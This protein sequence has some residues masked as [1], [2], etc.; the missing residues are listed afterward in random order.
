MLT[1]G[2]L[3][4]RRTVSS[5]GCSSSCSSC[6]WEGWWPAGRGP[7]RPAGTARRGSRRRRVAHLAAGRWFGSAFARAAGAARP[8]AGLAP[9]PGARPV[10]AASPY[11]CPWSGCWRPAPASGPACP[12]RCS[13]RCWREP[14]PAGRRPW[15]PRA[16]ARPLFRSLT[17]PPRRGARPEV[18]SGTAAPRPAPAA[19]RP[20]RGP[21]RR[22]TRRPATAGRAHRLNPAVFATHPQGDDLPLLPG[23]EGPPPPCH[24]P[25]RVPLPSGAGQA[26]PSRTEESSLPHCTERTTP[27]TRTRGVLAPAPAPRPGKGHDADDQRDDADEG[28]DG[29]PRPQVH[30]YPPGQRVPAPGRGVPGTA[31]RALVDLR[32]GEGREGRQQ[33]PR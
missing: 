10:T 26:S 22:R 12:V 4:H 17:G 6:C 27:W 9:R 24:T 16:H 20:A 18:L 21:R 32:H 33:P 3:L 14:P 30:R 28:D 1:G 13:A 5:P 31:G 15:R 25:S 29:Q 7:H 2:R 19:R 11:Y 23:A 8:V